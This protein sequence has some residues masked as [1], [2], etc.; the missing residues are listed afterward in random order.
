MRYGGCIV[1]GSELGRGG[2]FEGLG[3]GFFDESLFFGARSYGCLLCRFE[4]F[5]CFLS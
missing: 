5:L 4:C 2:S 3:D 1:E